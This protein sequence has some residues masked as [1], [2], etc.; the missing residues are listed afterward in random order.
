M[1]NKFLFYSILFPII[2]LLL[3]TFYKQNIYSN[4][5]EF[6]LNI[7]GYDPRD[8]ISG[9]FVTYRIEY[10]FNP[11]EFNEVQE[12]CIC[13]SQSESIPVKLESCDLVI[14]CDAFIKGKCKNNIFEAGIEK[15]FIPENKAIEIDKIVRGGKSK[16]KIA[17][18]K[19]GNALV[20]DLILIPE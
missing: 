17:V 1:K 19:K 7:S 20:K 5:K 8:L 3:L 13:L 14:S 15:Y 4:G 2:S 18:D 6:E 16:I 9:H 11:C 10:G 12:I